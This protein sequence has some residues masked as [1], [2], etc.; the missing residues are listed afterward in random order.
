MHC[1]YLADVHRFN[2]YDDA[3][4]IVA[5]DSDEKIKKDK[6]QDRP[7]FTQQE[8]KSA[9]LSIKQRRTVP[10]S[11]GYFD[12]PIIDEVKIFDTNEEL[13]QISEEDQDKI[14]EMLKGHVAV[15]VLDENGK[16][17]D[18]TSLQIPGVLDDLPRSAP[19]QTDAQLVQKS[20]VLESLIQRPL[21]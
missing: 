21:V 9:L 16:L 10:G 7:L 15:S 2:S 17:L 3:K 5:I 4:F 12:T 20:Q 14:A 1:C 18:A 8:R 13:E 19:R 11:R 6:G